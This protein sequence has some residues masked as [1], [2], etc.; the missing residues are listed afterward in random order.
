M[1][2]GRSRSPHLKYLPRT[3]SS[4]VERSKKRSQA[5]FEADLKKEGYHQLQRQPASVRLSSR[6]I[7]KFTL[8]T[9]PVKPG[10][11]SRA[12]PKAQI[13]RIVVAAYSKDEKRGA[14]INYPRIRPYLKGG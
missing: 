2:P 14:N 1:N 3:L 10:V 9:A 4:S 11:V 12:A 5:A 7:R 8:Y 6:R 13:K